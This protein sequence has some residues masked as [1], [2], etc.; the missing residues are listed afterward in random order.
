MRAPYAR[1]PTTEPN[2]QI[3]TSGPTAPR[4]PSSSANAVSATSSTPKLI[5]T[6]APA[7]TS[8]RIPGEPSAPARVRFTL[9]AG[10]HAREAGARAN[11]RAAPL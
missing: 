3:V 2:A 11:P 9:A 7:T 8:V 10:R 5:A 6:I 1:P 4:D